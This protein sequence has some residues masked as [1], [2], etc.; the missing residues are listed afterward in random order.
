MTSPSSGRPDLVT[1]DVTT[2]DTRISGTTR[3]AQTSFG[4][5]PYSKL[6]AL[7]VKDEVDMHIVLTLPAT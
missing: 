3:F 6:G 1:L 5:K 7:K 4:I 2:E